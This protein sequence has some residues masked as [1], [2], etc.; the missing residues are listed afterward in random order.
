LTAGLILAAGAGRRFGPEPKLLADLHG[1]PVLEHVVAAATAALDRVVVVLGAHADEIR[2]A[3]DVGSAEVTVAEDWAD[4]QAASLNHGLALLGDDEKILVLLGDQPLVSPDV[5]TRM[6]A[7]PPGSRAAHRG[8][9]GHPA[10]LGPDLMA[11]AETLTGDR[12]LRDL[13]DWRLVEVGAPAH[14]LDTPDDLEALRDE[15]RAVL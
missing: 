3:V 5:I 14:D 10:V 8:A 1:R 4:G 13:V 6:A 2:G 12:G 7:E 9:P 15:A 11:R